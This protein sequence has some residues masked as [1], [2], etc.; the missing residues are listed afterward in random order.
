[1]L[2]TVVKFITVFTYSAPVNTPLEHLGRDVEVFCTCQLWG[3][4]VF[5][6]LLDDKQH[7]PWERGTRG[8]KRTCRRRKRLLPKTRHC[9][10]SSLQQRVESLQCHVDIL[11]SARKD[12]LL[13]AKELRRA[14]EVITTQLN[15]LTEQLSSS[16]H[17]TQV[18]R[19]GDGVEKIPV[20]NV[21]QFLPY[22]FDYLS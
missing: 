20:L 7:E 2:I 12:A 6:L 13:S 16:K 8:E 5:F 1:M 10:S 18:T 11:Q 19:Q 4:C 17:L 14:N 9:S 21:I 22:Y 15:A 3:S